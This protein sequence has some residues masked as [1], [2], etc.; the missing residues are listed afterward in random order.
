MRQNRMLA[1]LLG[2]ALG[3]LLLSGIAAALP[4]P[5]VG[6]ADANTGYG[7]NIQGLAKLIFGRY[8]LAFE[9]T[10]ALLIGL[11]LSRPA[12]EPALP[13]Q[14]VPPPPLSIVPKDG[15]K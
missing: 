4:A 6:L 13:S 7:G 1:I 10:S 14:P 12:I 11:G 9:V 2:V 5:V 15:A 8:L 3:G